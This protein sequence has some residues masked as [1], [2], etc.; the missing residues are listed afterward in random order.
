MNVLQNQLLI[1]ILIGLVGFIS[2]VI[3]IISLGTWRMN[4]SIKQEIALLIEN[5]GESNRE[6]ITEKDL[7]KLP[8]PVKRWMINTGVVGKK[9][10]QTLH[11]KQ[12]GK[13]KLKPD[14]K[15]WF[16]PQAKQYIRVDKPS[17]LWHVN[18]P[19]LPI[20]NTNGRDLFWD[21]KGSMLIKIGS[22]IPV[23]DVSPNEKINESSLHRFLLEIPWY[24][25]A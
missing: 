7:E 16:I 2:L 17:Y 21:G 11:F 24:P 6:I 3:L 1:K 4:K 12:T 22:V 19:M 5:K 18:L 9:P 15:D 23:V 14:Q 8:A 20:I 13:M 25:T 10:I